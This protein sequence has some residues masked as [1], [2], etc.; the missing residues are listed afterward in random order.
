MDLSVSVSVLKGGERRREEEGEREG[1]REGERERGRE[2]GREGERERDKGG[3]GRLAH[4]FFLPCNA[5]TQ[6]TP[7]LLIP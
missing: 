6:H 5:L 3:R 7:L 4:C 1:G 2:R